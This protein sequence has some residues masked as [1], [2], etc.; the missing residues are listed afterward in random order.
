MAQQE[1][2]PSFKELETAGAIIGEIR[3]DTR[4]VFDL[5]DPRENNILFRLANKL[6]IQT[7]PSVVR[8]TLLFNSGDRLSVQLIEESERLLRDNHY[9]YD[10]SIRP[11]AYHDG[12]VDIEV[13]TRDTWT[14]TPGV[15]FSRQGGSN[16]SG[17]TLNENNLLGTGISIGLARTSD[18]DRSGNEFSIAQ[19]NAFGSRVNYEFR[20]GNFSDGKRE[21]FALARPFYALDSRWSAGVSAAKSDRIDSLY[22]GGTIIGQYRH[23]SDS[24]SIYGGY[25][26]GLVDGWTHRF[27]AGIQYQDDSYRT[28]PTLPTPSQVPQDLTQSGPFITYEVI[29]DDFRK[30]RNRDRIERAEYFAMGFNS[31]VQLGRAMTELGSTRDLWFYTANVSDG[32]AFTQ[33]RNLLTSA[34]TN[35]RYGSNGGEHQFFGAA[36]KYYSQQSRHTLFFASISADTVINGN[37]ADQLLLGGDNGLRGYPLRY[38]AGT[39]RAL[40]SLEQ[41]AY[42]EWFPF[43]LF[44]VGGA[45]FY[46]V[47]RAWNGLNQNTANPGWLSDVGIGLR[48]PYDRSSSGR[49]LH[50]DL[51]FP[52][53]R[54]PGIKS[55]QFLFKT[56]VSF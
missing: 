4:D 19:N 50:V 22:S 15:H 31:K 32:V 8:R 11:V 52:L 30:V 28:D 47:G 40:L 21:S 38:Q 1:G 33:D 39:R 46:D 2:L 14:L 3:I 49:V 41:R 13:K 54:E 42:T 56:K 51:A 20:Q 29:E 17:L 5:D 34:Y 9:L 6:H 48:I 10:V 44:R 43:R 12:I 25:S 23:A 18:V 7:R 26:R 27:Y 45:V 55:R 35:G 53:N 16:T 37:A 36:A 24:G